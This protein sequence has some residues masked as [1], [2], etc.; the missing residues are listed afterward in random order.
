MGLS[1]KRI[2][3]IEAHPDRVSLDQL[4]TVLM[5]LGAQLQVRTLNAGSD[6]IADTRKKA[7]W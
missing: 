4:L 5:A 6:T 2:S 7:P 3:S 1:Q